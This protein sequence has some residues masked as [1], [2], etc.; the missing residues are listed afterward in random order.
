[1]SRFRLAA[2]NYL[3]TITA[4]ASSMVLALFTAPVL[5]MWLG[6]EKWGAYR[7]LLN[8]VGHFGL[9]EFGLGTAVTAMLVQAYAKGNH[10]FQERIV[11][12]AFRWYAWV[13]A[14]TIVIGLCG[15]PIVCWLIPVAP[16]YVDDLF[17]GYLI[18][19]GTLL[20]LPLSPLRI[21]LQARQRSYIVTGALFAQMV[22]SILLSLLFAYA[23]FGISGQVLAHFVG[24]LASWSIMLLVGYRHVGHV[25]AR[26]VRT[27]P[28]EETRRRLWS[29][30]GP[31]FV[32][33]VSGRLSLMSDNIIVSI[34]L[35]PAAVTPFFLT[36]RL[37][38]LVEAQ[39]QG[40]A[41][42]G[43]AGLAEM[44][45]KGFHEVF[46]QRLLELTKLV[47]MAGVAILLPI[48]VFNEAF[49]SLWVGEQYYQGGMFTLVTSANALLMSMI[50]VWGMTL[51]GL[52]ILRP[53]AKVFALQTVVN[54]TFSIVLTLHLGSIGPVLGTLIS[55]LSITIWRLPL[56]LKAS[57][58][59]S[60]SGLAHVAIA[61]IVLGVM[62][63]VMWDLYSNDWQPTNWLELVAAILGALTLYSMSAVLL[64]CNQSER[65]LW[66]ERVRTFLGTRRLANTTTVQE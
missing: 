26:H 4:S 6:D 58:G 31:A 48:V 24:L 54:V 22:M 15:W 47:T 52:G 11:G 19:L 41:N 20:F 1:M 50:T 43:W 44:H 55:F 17:Y 30:N 13:T 7:I 42:A 28:S 60:L 57:F 39:L 45:A 5:L 14:V 51:R 32:M 36:Q 18:A 38:L 3:T 49:M 10:E 37:A 66:L 25:R 16:G 56:V 35:G 62:Q 8:V 27:K 29:L 46:N 23:Q 2:W 9:L 21:A 33:E 61:P 34:V 63:V 53:Q 65:R 64:I 12:T 59:T 40:L